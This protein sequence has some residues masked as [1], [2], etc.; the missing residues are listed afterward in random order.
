M[1]AFKVDGT[2]TSA[3]VQG[4]PHR[5][6]PFERDLTAFIEEQR[7]MILKANFARLALSTPHPTIATAFL[8]QETDL[9]NLG[10]GLVEWTRRYATVPATRSEYE[11]YA[12][13]FPAIYDAVGSD[14]YRTLPL[15]LKVAARVEFA[16]YHVGVDVAY[17][18]VE[19]IPLVERFSPL[20]S[21]SIDAEV[22]FVNPSTVPTATEYLAMVAAEDE[23][24]VEDSELH[25]WLGNI[26]E[27]VT[28]YVKA[29]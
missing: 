9:Q 19:D 27:R 4:G 24:A 13:T 25:P 22:D 1:S 28:R 17:P 18:T 14:S 2:F 11:S 26:Y 3:A 21:A 7:Y 10:S 16:Y 6:F 12:V 23:I 5:T 29:R 20:Y 15:S 8:V